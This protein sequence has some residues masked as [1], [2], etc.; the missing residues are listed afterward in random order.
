[1]SPSRST[2]VDGIATVGGVRAAWF[3]DPDGYLL[4][5]MEGAQPNP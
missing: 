3:K 1:V 5:I 2:T 4:A